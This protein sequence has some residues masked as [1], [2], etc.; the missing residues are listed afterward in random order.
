M[1]LNRSAEQL[2]DLQVN[3]G[4]YLRV[5]LQF[6]TPVSTP[7]L[8]GGESVTYMRSEKWVHYVPY[9][10][11]SL[12]TFRKEEE[13]PTEIL[14]PDVDATETQEMIDL[15]TPQL[16]LGIREEQHLAGQFP[17]T[18]EGEAAAA[19]AAETMKA[20]RLRRMNAPTDPDGLRSFLI[21]EFEL[22]EGTG[23]VISE[24]ERGEVTR[25][26]EGN[27]LPTTEWYYA[28]SE[29]DAVMREIDGI[30]SDQLMPRE[31]RSACLRLLTKMP[32][33]TAETYTPSSQSSFSG[34]LSGRA[35]T[36]VNTGERD[37]E[38][39][40]LVFDAETA[41][42]LGSQAV[43]TE[44]KDLYPGLEPGTVVYQQSMTTTV[45]DSVPETETW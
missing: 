34:L 23:I 40:Q 21:D 18:A 44:R 28:I 1:L 17:L 6:Q 4:Q 20:D 11:A 19:V 7:V 35:A 14:L 8:E 16:T 10:L 36:F 30:V 45:V 12:W 24:D 22:K 27:L 9:D 25:D 37:G 39:H 31:L 15:I 26:E 43:L 42:L 2:P 32:G 29:D 13:I 5:E 3:A 41:D 33:V 38:S